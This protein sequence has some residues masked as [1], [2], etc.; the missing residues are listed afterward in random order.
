MD[1]NKESNM[2]TAG[3]CK[4]YDVARVAGV[5]AKTVSKVINNK[6]GVAEKTREKILNVISELGYQPHI[7]A[8]MLRGKSALSVG[9]TILTSFRTLPFKEHALFAL[10]SYMP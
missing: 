6:S 7:G 2:S 4:I 5:S 9:V 8:R 3:Q 1:N 10:F